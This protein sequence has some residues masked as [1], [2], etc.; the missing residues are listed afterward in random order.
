VSDLTVSGVILKRLVSVT[1]MVSFLPGKV[2]FSERAV[3]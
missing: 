3:F 1:A 2:S